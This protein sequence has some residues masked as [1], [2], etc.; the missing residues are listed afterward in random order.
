M[1]AHGPNRHC[2][3]IPMTCGCCGKDF[4]ATRKWGKWCSIECGIAGRAGRRRKRYELQQG[5]I[6][7]I[8]EVCDR[9]YKSGG[10]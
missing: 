4:I 8:D 3:N 6:E 1:V 5:E 2:W 9:A 10:T 7:L